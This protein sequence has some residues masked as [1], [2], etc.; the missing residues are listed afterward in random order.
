MGWAEV[1]VVGEAA[2]LNNEAAPGDGAVEDVGAEEGGQSPFFEVFDLQRL[3]EAD[4]VSGGFQPH[5]EF[6]VFDAGTAV[7]RREAA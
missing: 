6:D 4:G 3:V 7:C 1:E 2:V 5:S